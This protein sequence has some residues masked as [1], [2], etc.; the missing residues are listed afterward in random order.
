[1]KKFNS[2][3]LSFE[4]VVKR[5]FCLNHKALHTRF[6][7]HYIYRFRSEFID[8][9]GLDPFKCVLCKFDSQTTLFNGRPIIMELDHIN[10][11]VR[12][13][14]PFNLRFLCPNCHTQTDNYKNRTRTIEEIHEGFMWMA[15]DKK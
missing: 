8:N 12:D 9:F 5:H 11:Q 6:N 7:K 15:N 3:S 1:M 13:G 2:Q 10:A 14:R 4:E